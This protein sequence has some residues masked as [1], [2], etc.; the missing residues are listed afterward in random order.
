MYP[1]SPEDLR[2]LMSGR[3]PRLAVGTLPLEVRRHFGR[4]EDKVFLS[5]ESVVHILEKHGEHIGYE[6][7]LL[8]PKILEAGLW[9]GEFNRPEW[10]SASLF[11][12]DE[13]RR[14]L[15]AIKVTKDRRES[16]VATLHQAKPR[17]IR[18]KMRRGIILRQ[19]W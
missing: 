8:I 13:N 9:I 12:E 18:S 7:L 1:L 4:S 5:S 14:L 3:M 17:Q 15:A 10:C 11:L 16:F 6:E 2:D 19:H